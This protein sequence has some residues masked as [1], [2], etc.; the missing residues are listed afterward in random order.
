[1]AETGAGGADPLADRALWHA[2]EFEALVFVGLEKGAVI[3]G[4]RTGTDHLEHAA[5]ID[6]PGQTVIAIAGIV[7]DDREVLGALIVERFEQGFRN[8]HSAK[9]RYQDGRAI[10]DPRNRFRG[11]LDTFVDHSPELP[12]IG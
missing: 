9:S 1:A 4:A 11:V 10:L 5:R 6:E 7:G 8:A 3:A 2:V 12:K